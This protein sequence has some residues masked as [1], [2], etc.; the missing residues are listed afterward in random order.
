MRILVSRTDRIGDVVLTLPL[1]A[2]LR[3]RLGAEVV[4]LGRAYTRPVLE[5]SPHVDEVLDWD[6]VAQAGSAAQR[7]FLAAA[8][9]DV[10]VHVFPR[11]EIARAARA[12]GIRTRIGTS[13]RLYHWLTCNVLEHFSRRASPLH[14]AQLNVR[15]AASLLRAPVP[16]LDALRPLTA[17]VPRVELP[18]GIAAQVVTGRPTM[19]LHPKSSASAREWP[20][21]HWSTLATSLARDGAQVIV[22][23]SA[24]EGE[25][26]APWLSGLDVPVLNLTGRLSLPEL[27]A[28]FARVTGVVAAST[29]P[30][31]VAAGVG[32]H[33]LGL[34]SPTVPIHPGRWAP[35]GPRAEYLVAEPACAACRHTSRSGDAC[36]CLASITPVAVRQRIS[37]WLRDD[38]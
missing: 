38:R 14:E 6:E 25:Q 8:R 3:E 28:L 20:L 21:D 31:H 24:A 27:I 10:I 34:Y 29:G 11:R 30:L 15:L 18:A 17:L 12:A 26:L 9:A 4:A 2:L 22:T 5:A 35:L 23:G 19:V 1:C 37:R 33:A 36:D 7:D 16:P 32:T 13:H